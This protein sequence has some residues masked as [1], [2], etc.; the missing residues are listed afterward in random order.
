MTAPARI[1]TMLSDR[2]RP[3][4]SVLTPC[5]APGMKTSHCCD[6]TWNIETVRTSNGCAAARVAGTL[7]PETPCVRAFAGGVR[8]TYGVPASASSG[9]AG[10]VGSVCPAE[11]PR[12]RI[13]TMLSADSAV[14]SRLFTRSGAPGM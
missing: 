1:V 8:R 4:W 9:A 6:G 11:D 12:R 7:V 14:G 10:T 2:R 3:R 5:G 13:V